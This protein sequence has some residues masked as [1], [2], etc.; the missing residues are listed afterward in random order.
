MSEG[1]RVE[2]PACLVECYW[3]MQEGATRVRGSCVFICECVLLNSLKPFAETVIDLHCTSAQTAQFMLSQSTCPVSHTPSA[4]MFDVDTLCWRLKVLGAPKAGLHNPWPDRWRN[5]DR[6]PTISIVPTLHKF[7]R[8]LRS[9]PGIRADLP[10]RHMVRGSE[11]PASGVR[12]GFRDV[13]LCGALKHTG[14]NFGS[15]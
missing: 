15:I 1:C 13:Y 14:V 5:T 7:R 3:S 2:A 9:Q 10:P 8:I 4:A 12:A 11:S 6:D